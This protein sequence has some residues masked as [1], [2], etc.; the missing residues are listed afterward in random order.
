MKELTLI[1]PYYRNRCMLERQLKE[2]EAYP[3]N[4][5]IFVIDDGSP[6]PALHVITAAHPSERLAKRLRLYRITVDIPWNREGARNLGASQCTSDWLVHIDI[7]HLLPS[8]AAHALARFNPDR[9]AWYRFARFRYGRADETRKKDDIDPAVT[10][11][12]IK[13]HIDSYLLERK[14]YMELGGYDEDFA[15]VLGGGT[16][17]LKRLEAKIGAPRQLPDECCL[18]VY[19]RDAI[20]DASDLS[21]SRDTGPGKAIAR[22]KRAAPASGPQ[23]MLRFPWVREL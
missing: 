6:E 4:I 14:L 1:V 19:T 8:A 22:A 18:H 11:G 3:K 5:R 2:W 7:D 20:S 17:F 10:F 16:D 23:S 12:R 9:A 13:P 21:L 15:G